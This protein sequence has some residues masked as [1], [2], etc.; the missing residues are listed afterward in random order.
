MIDGL[1]TAVGFRVNSRNRFPLTSAVGPV[2]AS[3]IGAIED[4]L[5]DD[6]A[7]PIQITVLDRDRLRILETVMVSPDAAM[8][9]TNTTLGRRRA[10]V[11]RDRLFAG[12]SAAL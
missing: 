4:T 2:S 12:T 7:L 5:T 9:M 1:S 8:T 6:V 10:Y 11:L 3:L